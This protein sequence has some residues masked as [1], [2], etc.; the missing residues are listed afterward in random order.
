[1]QGT[2]NTFKIN[3]YKINGPSGSN[4]KSIQNIS[5][6]MVSATDSVSISEI[7]LTKTVPL[8]NLSTTTS[9]GFP[10]TAAELTTSTNLQLT[11]GG[12]TVGPTVNIQ[13]IEY[14]NVKS[15]QSGTLSILSGSTT[16]NV[17][18]STYNPLNSI[19]YFSYYLNV[20]D[21]AGIVSLVRGEKTDSTN[22]DFYSGTTTGAK[23]I[24]WYLVE[25]T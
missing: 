3:N 11:K 18:V 22:I 19:L 16:A 4:I 8:V 5:H 24:I 15:L 10:H 25:F 6:A 9:G 14:N 21:P 13:I 12:A 7:D 23:N 1:M 2:L 20:A 17:S